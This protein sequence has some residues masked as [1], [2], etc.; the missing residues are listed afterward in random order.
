MRLFQ[1]IFFLLLLHQSV[2]AQS[3][4]EELA[5]YREKYINGLIAEERRPIT[6]E[7]KPY[8]RYYDADEQY[9]IV[10]AFIKTEKAQPIDLP[11]SAGKIKKY[12]EYGTLEFILHSQPCTLK[13]YQSVA[14]M[15]KS[16]YKNYLFLP[17]TDATSGDETY[18]NG[19]YLE[20]STN[21]IKDGKLVIDFNKAYN[22]YCAYSDGFNCPKP[23]EANDLKAKIEAG[24][25]QFGVV[26]H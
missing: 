19:R 12:L 1:K 24:E 10:A 3:Y 8:I 23:P 4:K 22:P 6:A 14:L 26:R 18:I 21:D 17:F 5:A 15:E 13:I 2:F 16:E 11:T 25:K 7:D 20:F 9:K